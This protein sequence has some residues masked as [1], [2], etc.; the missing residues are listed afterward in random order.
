FH[1]RGRR[2]RDPCAPGRCRVAVHRQSDPV[3][4]RPDIELAARRGD[5]DDP[6]RARRRCHGRARL[7]RAVPHAMTAATAETAHTSAASAAALA[8]VPRR[9]RPRRFKN[10]GA[11]VF[12]LFLAFYLF[13]PLV[14]VVLFSFNATASLSFPIAGFSTRWYNK[15]LDDP[16]VVAALGRSAIAAF[17][18]GLVAGTLG[19]LAALG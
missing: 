12:L 16:E 2:L 9:R 17:T 6:D 19:I 11:R 15:V 3:P 13:A 4:D 18:T 14:V 8:A 7:G 10:L 5:G 1:R